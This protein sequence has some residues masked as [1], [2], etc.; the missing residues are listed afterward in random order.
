MGWTMIRVER[1]RILEVRAICRNHVRMRLA[2]G[3][4]AGESRPGQF[5]NVR[6]TP[7][8][9]SA[10]AFEGWSDYARTCEHAGTGT[11]GRTLLLRPFAVHRA[12]RE[13]PRKGQIEI[14]FKVVGKGT[15]A[16]AGKK[17]GES[18]DLM[19][20]LGRGFDLDRC[21]RLSTA[22]VVAGG[23]GVAPL[24][25]LA[26]FLRAKHVH[27]LVIVGAMSEKDLPLDAA[28]RRVTL[29]FMET[30]PEAT[31]TAEEFR[32][33]GCETGVVLME[34][35]KGYVGLPTDMLDRFL[36]RTE[37]GARGEAAVFT[38]GPWAMMK[39]VA[40]HAA[41]HDVRCEALLEER[42]GCG[43]GACMACSIRVRKCGG[44][45]R[46]RVCIEGPVFDASEVIWDES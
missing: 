45:V 6:C 34:G 5:V 26:E 40:R 42:M 27:T 2:A 43:V 22:V 46:Q 14:L 19:G 21:A 3:R 28:D 15:R 18:I 35:T 29:S 25:P 16:L 20:P 1:A 32:S 37:G 11:A 9:F 23:V 17:P 41:E 10:R 12:W 38:C 31:I 4:I 39:A 30:K 8:A 7:M 44:V 24:F 36:H 13:G 33:L